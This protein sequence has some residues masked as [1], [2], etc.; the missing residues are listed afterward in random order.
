MNLTNHKFSS[1][2]SDHKFGIDR[3]YFTEVKHVFGPVVV[4]PEVIELQPVVEPVVEL[5]EP[6]IELIEEIPEEPV[7]K[8]VEEVIV[9][10]SKSSESSEPLQTI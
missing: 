1:Q 9:E 2:N 10:P 5:V 3:R 7:L 6:A 4:E 8:P